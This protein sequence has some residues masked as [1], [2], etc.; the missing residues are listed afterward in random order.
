M[1]DTSWQLRIIRRWIGKFFF[2]LSSTLDCEQCLFSSKIRG[3]E[4]KTS[5]CASVSVSGSRHCRSYV[6]LTS[7][8]HAT[9]LFCVLPY[10]FSRKRDTARSLFRHWKPLKCCIKH[11]F[12][13]CV[14]CENLWTYAVLNLNHSDQDPGTSTFW[15][16]LDWISN[17]QYKNR[18]PFSLFKPRYRRLE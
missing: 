4:G 15:S 2:S 11:I 7:R 10:G 1:A 17:L 3:E 14:F 16:K 8:S 12:H 5:K 6:T 13:D 18:K 9:D